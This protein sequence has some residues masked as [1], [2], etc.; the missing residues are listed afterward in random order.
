MGDDQI[1][2]KH[3]T[4]NPLGIPQMTPKLMMV[5]Q[6]WLWELDDNT[7]VTSFPA[8]ESADRRS[9]DVLHS[10]LKSIDSALQNRTLRSVRGLIALIAA[11]CTGVFHQHD[12][13]ADVAFFHFFGDAIGTAQNEHFAAFDRF[14]QTSADLETGREDT[15]QCLDSLFSIDE[16]IRLITRL[17]AIM[18]DLQ[19]IDFICS[20]QQE[21]L[22]SLKKCSNRSRSL[23]EVCE[24]VERRRAAW[25]GMA[26]TAKGTY[27]AL[28]DLMD[29][30]QRQANVS[31]ARTS[32]AQ[33]EV[34]A[35]HGRSIMLFTIVTIIFLPMSVLA[36]IFGINAKQFNADNSLDFGLISIIL[37]PV[38]FAIALV[39][40]ILAFNETLRDLVLHALIGL[41]RFGLRTFRL[42]GITRKIHRSSFRM[43]QFD[44]EQSGSRL[45]PLRRAEA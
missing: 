22:Q 43:R 41:Y 29:L 40:L 24:T 9:S 28:R 5:D 19:K 11:T 25:A 13:P 37:F 2:R 6:L 10:I 7:L 14:R 8:T 27:E 39:A 16:E 26:E 45:Q 44:I 12:I 38:S 42:E 17:K 3:T 31:E 34:S 23:S 35:R 4:D 15:S 33:V 1:I 36:G 32:R 21:V 30:K 20:Q 18:N